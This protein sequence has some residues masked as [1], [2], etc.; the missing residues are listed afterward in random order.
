[1]KANKKKQI[2]ANKKKP[3]STEQTKGDINSGKRPALL[4]C[5]NHLN[6]RFCDEEDEMAVEIR[7]SDES[8]HLTGEDEDA[9]IKLCAGLFLEDSA[10]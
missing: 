8:Q 3:S 7:D 10:S 2:W 5:G 1:M 4:T 9:E 6:K